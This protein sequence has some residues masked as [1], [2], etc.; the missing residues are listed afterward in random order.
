MS[1]ALATPA[2]AS[3]ARAT[4]PRKNGF[5]AFDSIF[6]LMTVTSYIIKGKLTVP[7]VPQSH[8]INGLRPHGQAASNSLYSGDQL[9]GGPL[10]WS[11]S[12]IKLKR[13]ARSARGRHPLQSCI[14]L[15]MRTVLRHL[16]SSCFVLTVAPQEAQ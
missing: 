15:F 1:A 11:N 5:M 9:I 10:R 12:A 4:P 6:D 3:A 16:Y 7:Q 14:S 13:R 2:V 8:R